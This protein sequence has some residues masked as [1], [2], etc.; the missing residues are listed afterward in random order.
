MQSY[1]YWLMLCG[2]D[3]AVHVMLKDLNTILSYWGTILYN[4]KIDLQKYGHDELIIWKSGAIEREWRFRYNERWQVLCRQILM[5]GFF[6][7]QSF[8]PIRLIGLDYGPL[9]SDWKIWHSE[10]TDAS[11][12]DFWRL[13]EK[14]EELMPGTWID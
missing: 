14:K 12:G 13:I 11:V 2:I 9:T 6:Q 10:P 5:F 3:K 1:D 8:R 4:A 7:S